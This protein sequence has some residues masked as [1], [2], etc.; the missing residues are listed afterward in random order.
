MLDRPGPGAQ[1]GCD[2]PMLSGDDRRQGRG[3][4]LRASAPP[5]LRP[6][7]GQHPKSRPGLPADVR[8]GLA[9]GRRRLPLPRPAA[10]VP[11]R[12]PRP[13]AV[14]PG[15]RAAGRLPAQS[16]RHRRAAAAD[17]RRAVRVGGVA[18]L[19]GAPAAGAALHAGR[20]GRPHGRGGPRHRG[21]AGELG[22]ACAGRRR[23]GR[24]G[25]PRHGGQLRDLLRCRARPRAERAAARPLDRRRLRRPRDPPAVQRSRRGPAAVPPVAQGAGAPRHCGLRRHRRPAAGARAGAP[26]RR[27]RAL[28]DAPRATR[29]DTASPTARSATR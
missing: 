18:A 6:A 9:R 24:H 17:G 11:G 16:A 22:R 5:R 14:R 19:G 3:A 8:E 1:R 25:P 29:T 26:G 23:A 27:R 7:P 10:H 12:A 28:W 21:A 20:R 2:P 15:G 4:A 13:R